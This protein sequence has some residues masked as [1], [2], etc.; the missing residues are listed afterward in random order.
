MRKA[1]YALAL[2]YAFFILFPEKG[3][4]ADFKISP[5]RL[6]FKAGQRTNVIKVKNNSDET[7]TLQASVYSWR[8]DEEAKDLYSSTEDIIAFPKIFNIEGRG[9]RIIRV[10]TRVPPGKEEKTYRI[11]LE[12]IPRPMKKPVEQ[13]TVRTMMRFGIPLFIAPVETM[14]A[15]I[16]EEIKLT[17]G[18]LSFSVK[19]SGNVH[20]VIRAAKVEGTDAQGA[21][22]LKKDLGGW[23]I[24][25][26]HSK[27]FSLKIPEEICLKITAINIEVITD[28]LSMSERLNVTQEMCSL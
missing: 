9:E 1:L 14:A 8:Q 7:I 27:R 12:E 26:K 5:V 16:I 11:Y 20:F 22:L 23:Y 18:E 6:F 3:I 2:F 13:T 24:H 28:K 19:N 21:S 17:E 10:G 15:G 4:P 25:K